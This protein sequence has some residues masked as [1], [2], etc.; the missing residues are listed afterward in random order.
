MYTLPTKE[1]RQFFSASSFIKESGTLPVLQYMKIDFT[2]DGAK[3]YRTNLDQYY[4]HF[5]DVENT[6]GEILVE[7]NRLSNFV[8]KIQSDAVVFKKD[9]NTIHVSSGKEHVKL[10][11]MDKA[12][13]PVVPKINEEKT[14]I[15]NDVVL[16]L[17]RASKFL[18]DDKNDLFTTHVFVGKNYICAS[19]RNFAHYATLETPIELPIYRSIIDALPGECMHSLSDNYYTFT[20][21][22]GVYLFIKS[23]ASFFDMT[24]VPQSIPQK[25][26]TKISK[27]DFSTFL[28]IARGQCKFNLC[29]AE[30]TGSEKSMNCYMKDPLTEDVA[31]WPID[32]DG[33]PFDFKFNVDYM[34]TI[35]KQ[36]EGEELSM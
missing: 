30:I 28:N 19:D 9:G 22:N 32:A 23:E 16:T 10:N 7:Y 17:K 6:A 13:F 25:P 14:L 20:T 35:C 5:I 1:L 31:E 33:S 34:I 4:I 15:P 29:L 36:F 12:V 8:S 3:L 27:S 2:K 26:T 18:N 11:V 21:L 24:K